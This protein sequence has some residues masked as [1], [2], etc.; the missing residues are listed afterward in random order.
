M[1]TIHVGD[2]AC[3]SFQ[4]VKETI[5]YPLDHAD[6]TDIKI[7]VFS[8][9]DSSKV[10]QQFSKIVENDFEQLAGDYFIVK[11]TADFVNH[12][13]MAEMVVKFNDADFANNTQELTGTFLLDKVK[14]KKYGE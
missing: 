5:E 1:K 8:R 11:P 12:E 2:T 9:M 10:L 6:L 4:I 3:Y 13:L 7:T 14:A